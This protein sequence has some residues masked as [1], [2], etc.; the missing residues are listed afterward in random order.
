M[1]IPFVSFES[2]NKIIK[3]EIVKAFDD[4]FNKGYYILGQNV[5]SFEKSYAQF[6]KVKYCVGVSNGLDAL[7]M[8]LRILEIKKGDEVI[9]PSNTYIATCLAVSYVNATPILV[10][11]DIQTYNIDVDKIEAAIT[12]KTKAIIPVH[13]YGQACN[14]EKIMQLADK[15]KLYVIEDNAQSHGAKYK[16]KLTGS[17][18][19]INATSFYPGK[20][21]GA[22]GDAGAI[23]TNYIEWAND[24]IILRNYG[25]EKK[26][27]N[28]VIGF[29]MRLDECQAAFLSVKLKYLDM[30][31]SQRQE[32]AK[33]YREGLKGVGDIIIPHTLPAATHVYHVFVIRTKVR[34]RLQEYLQKIGI[35]TLIHYPIPPHRQ[36]AYKQST[37]SKKRFPIAE[38]ISDTCL[39]LPL[40][41]GI[42]QDQIEKVIL[43]IKNFYNG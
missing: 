29:N 21:L 12:P 1:D 26:Y 4:F 25:S 22:L 13:L 5:K 37:I 24:A 20:N 42:S 41:P 32:A 19:H 31:T 3:S 40:W 30:W 10:E 16:K 38:E 8:A 11:P 28:D 36:K 23:T 35:G 7:H 14:M 6:N 34:N 27:Y 2:S 17:W 15:H 9:V 39:S 18:G 33:Y 43:N